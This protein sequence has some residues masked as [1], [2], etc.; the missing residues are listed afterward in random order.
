MDWT[1]W[2]PLWRLVTRIKHVPL[3][4]VQN[5]SKQHIVCVFDL[6]MIENCVYTFLKHRTYVPI[7][8]P[9]VFNVDQIVLVDPRAYFQQFP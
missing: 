9:Y 7:L 1:Y 2:L 4:L 6:V 5:D 3:V 8:S